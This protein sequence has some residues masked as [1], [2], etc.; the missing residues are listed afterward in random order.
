MCVVGRFI[1]TR[2]HI[3]RMPQN[4]W[5]N[6]C[7]FLQIL[8]IDVAKGFNIAES[9]MNQFTGGKATQVGVIDV[10]AK[11]VNASVCGL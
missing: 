5:L 3:R 7:H 8:A 1:F 9:T 11:Q 4:G 10:T 6:S 2:H